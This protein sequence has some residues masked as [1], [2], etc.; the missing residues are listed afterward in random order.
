MQKVKA[1][2]FE[3]N[4]SENLKLALPVGTVQNPVVAAAEVVAVVVVAA[5]AEQAG[6]APCTSAKAVTSYN[7]IKATF[8]S[9][10]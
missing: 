9:G 10:H 8:Y 6:Q 5:A 1:K 4:N 3:V 7:S 2:L